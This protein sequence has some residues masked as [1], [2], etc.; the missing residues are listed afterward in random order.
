MSRETYRSRRDGL[1]AQDLL[2]VLQHAQLDE[3]VNLVDLAT[4]DTV[5]IKAAMLDEES[6]L[7]LLL[8]VETP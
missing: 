1:T 7:G 5:P 3:A 8:Y 4:G 6:D 2:N